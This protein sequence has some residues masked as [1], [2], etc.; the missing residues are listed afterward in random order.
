MNRVG[1]CVKMVVGAAG[2]RQVGRFEGTFRIIFVTGEIVE[3]EFIVRGIVVVTGE[4]VNSWAWSRRL[5]VKKCWR[6]RICGSRNVVVVIHVRSNRA[7]PGSCV[8]YLG[9]TRAYT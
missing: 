2:E 5:L 3:I 6:K 8:D 9:E 1:G 4:T 7:E